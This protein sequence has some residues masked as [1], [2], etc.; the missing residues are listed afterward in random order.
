MQCI[1]SAAFTCATR[2]CCSWRAALRV[3]TALLRAWIFASLVVLVMLALATA[4]AG[5]AGAGAAAATVAA[6]RNDGDEVADAIDGEC[7]RQSEYLGFCTT[8]FR[9]ATAGSVV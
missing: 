6:G 3:V 8:A 2:F 9:P 5:G 1:T 7:A 4:A